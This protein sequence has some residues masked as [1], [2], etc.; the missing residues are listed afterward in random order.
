MMIA[1]SLF[2]ILPTALATSNEAT[3]L[4]SSQWADQ[5]SLFYKD[6][7]QTVFK[8]D[9]PNEFN[10]LI[11]LFASSLY[12]TR[13]YPLNELFSIEKEA[14]CNLSDLINLIY[15]SKS[16][17]ESR[18]L[19]PENTTGGFLDQFSFF[20]LNVIFEMNKI[21]KKCFFPLRSFSNLFIDF[22]YELSPS[23]DFTPISEV[24]AKIEIS[25]DSIY[26]FIKENEGTTLDSSM[27]ESLKK[28]VDIL[29]TDCAYFNNLSDQFFKT[30][31]EDSKL[32]MILNA[33]NLKNYFAS[34]GLTVDSLIQVYTNNAD[35]NNFLKASE[36][37]F[38]LFQSIL[39]LSIQ[40]KELVNFVEKFTNSKS[41]R[42]SYF[43]VFFNALKSNPG[44]ETSDLMVTQREASQK[45]HSSNFFEK[46][47]KDVKDIE[48]S[49][50]DVVFTIEAPITEIPLQKEEPKEDLPEE[51][52]VSSETEKKS[53]SYEWASF[54][55]YLIPA[56]SVISIIAIGFAVY[57]IY[58]K[59][60]SNI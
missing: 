33:Y 25:I 42:P 47:Q 10:S 17:K 19:Y 28:K 46:A 56:A 26:S 4:L 32:S 15:N 24:L 36:G 18:N 49:I 3:G 11:N 60:S 35:A 48:T 8:V 41:S 13:N 57:G 21:H 44:K 58:K 37:I 2:S 16:F 29:R 45:F 34:L 52:K 6:V 55:R 31:T 30:L 59:K 54:V 50:S 7:Q 23:T 9:S 12:Q 27:V 53:S 43:G 5:T 20:E 51:P 38:N 14:N 40:K 39:F 22:L 1:N